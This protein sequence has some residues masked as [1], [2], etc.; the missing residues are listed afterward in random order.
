MFVTGVKEH[1]SLFLVFGGKKGSHVVVLCRNKWQCGGKYKN[2]TKL[3]TNK[4]LSQERVVWNNRKFHW[5]W[6]KLCPNNIDERNSVENRREC[7][8]KATTPPGGTKDDKNM[9]I[10]EKKTFLDNGNSVV[11]HRNPVENKKNVGNISAFQ[12]R[13]QMILGNLCIPSF[14]TTGSWFLLRSNVS[15]TSSMSHSLGFQ[16]ITNPLLCHQDNFFLLSENCRH[17]L[18]S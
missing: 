5:D 8:F 12:D 4:E 2:M 10:A 1:H 9:T 16:R 14:L 17:S 3:M 15:A 6:L 18:I 7:A 11:K 13:L